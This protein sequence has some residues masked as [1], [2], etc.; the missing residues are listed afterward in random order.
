[1]KNKRHF[2]KKI[3]AVIITLLTFAS[4]VSF[5]RTATATVM[6]SDVI[7]IDDNGQKTEVGK[8]SD[9]IKMAETEAELE[10]EEYYHIEDDEL[11]RLSESARKAADDFNKSAEAAAGDQGITIVD[12]NGVEKNPAF[13]K[14]WSLILI[15]KDNWIPDNYAFR[16]T[17]ISGTVKSDVR[18]AP[19][20]LDM[21]KAAREEGIS[22]YV[23]SGYR[24]MTRQTYVFNRKVQSLINE[25][26]DEEEAKRLAAEVVAVP[27]TSEHTVGLAFDLVTAGHSRLDEEFA[28]TDGGM[29]LKEHGPEYGF[30]LRYPRGKEDVT[31]IEFE[32]W[33]YRFVGV[34]A[35]REI[36]RLGVTL[37]EYDRMIGIAE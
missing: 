35:A 26:H 17:T 18:V 3:T 37:E 30:I 23:A 2:G 12:E 5:S 9:V 13:S 27:G 19:Y 25:G 28:Y 4:S 22:L 32:P 36:T 21:I 6:N 20:L 33:H 10:G 31:G 16:L 1:M 15:N 8:Y 11:D 29:W 34:D 14:D 24:D 7:I